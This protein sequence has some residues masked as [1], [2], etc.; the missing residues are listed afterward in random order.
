MATKK[1]VQPKSKQSCS[2]S[3]VFAE[4]QRKAVQKLFKQHE[5]DDNTAFSDE[6]YEA[7]MK[8]IEAA[9]IAWANED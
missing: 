4:R 3:P 5:H 6:W 2:M 1:P 9:V 7:A 8:R